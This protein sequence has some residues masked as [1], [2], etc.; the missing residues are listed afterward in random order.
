LHLFAT[1]VNF[2]LERRT[3]SLEKIPL[4]AL[5]P[6]DFE[7]ESAEQF[8]AA[9][10]EHLRFPQ[11]LDTYACI[12]CNRCAHVCPANQTGKALTPAAQLGA[13]RL[14][15]LR[16][17]QLLA[18]YACIQCSRCA[19]ACPANQAGKARSPAALEINNRYELN[20]IAAA[21]AA[22]EE[23]PRPLVEFAIPPEAV[24]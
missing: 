12:Q 5:E 13:A 19:N 1:P 2:A 6:I 18:T 10:L 17:P 9:R 8:G 4:G 14:G 7:D 20:R 16:F 23:S 21:F 11:L 15:H 24:W 3:E 22:G